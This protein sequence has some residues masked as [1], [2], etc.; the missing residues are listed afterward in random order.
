MKKISQREARRM[1]KEL[2]ALRKRDEARERS[3]SSEYPDAIHIASSSPSTDVVAII[4][5]AR[6][7]GHA[8]I[9][10]AEGDGKIFYY[11]AKKEAA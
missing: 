11:A 2:Q 7:L 5:T 3:W 8:V 9:C 4:K 6:K 10:T 1:R